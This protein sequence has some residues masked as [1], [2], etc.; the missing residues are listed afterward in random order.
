MPLHHTMKLAVTCAIL[1]FAT[2]FPSFAEEPAAAPKGVQ[3]ELTSEFIY[4][5][6]VG[7]IAGQRGDLGLAG[8]LFYD[9]AKSSRDA[10]LAERAAK[11]AIFSNNPKGA[12]QATSLWM[13]LDPSSIEAQQATTEMMINTGNLVGAK[14]YL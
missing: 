1:S 5:Y 13:E 7:E 4:K 12:M 3:T 6:L 2:A 10:R 14:P 11:V 8:N 9:L